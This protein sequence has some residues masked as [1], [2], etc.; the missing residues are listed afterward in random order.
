MLHVIANTRFF[1]TAFVMERLRGV[2]G[3]RVLPHGNHDRGLTHSLAKFAEASLPWVGLGSRA[4]AAGYLAQL[5]A[6]EPSDSV[7]VF[8]VENIKELRILRRHIRAQRRTLFTWNPVGTTSRTRC[9]AWC[10]SAP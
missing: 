6:I 2:E 8:G 4:F 10:T 9:C 7:L 5:R 3:V 1:L